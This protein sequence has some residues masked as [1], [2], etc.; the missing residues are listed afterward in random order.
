MKRKYA[1]WKEMYDV[2]ARRR[3]P[4]MATME[5]T[6][7]CNLSCVHCYVCRGNGKREMGFS[8]VKK[9][10]D[11]LDAAGCLFLTLTGGEVFL[12]SDL[13]EILDYLDT[14]QFIL[15]VFTNGTLIDGA[16][17][18]RLSRYRI[19]NMGISVYSAKPEVHDS[20]TGNGLV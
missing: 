12:R 19:W 8:G 7:R 13:H 11:G 17:A 1:V 9:A 14:K 18:R 2:S 5:L 10:I 15:Q 4:L 20:V 6:Y 3:I 16:A